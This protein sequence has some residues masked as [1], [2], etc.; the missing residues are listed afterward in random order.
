M[1]A[2]DWGGLYQ[3]SLEQTI[4]DHYVKR[5]R[6]WNELNSAIDSELHDS[7]RSY[8]QCSWYNHWSSVIIQD[9]FNDHPSVLPVIGLVKKVDFFIHDFPFDL[10]VTYFPDGYLQLL[11][12]REGLRPELAE[13]KTFCRSANIW[14]DN[15][16]PPSTLFMELIAKIA[17]HPSDN[18]RDFIT[19]FRATR[20]RLI[21]QTIQDPTDLKVW[22]YENQGVRRFDA[23][24][25][26][27]LI[28][29]D[30]KH[31][32]DS[33]KLKRNKVLLVEDINN[34]LNA[35][36]PDVM[37]SLKLSFKWRDE[38]FEAYSDI[39]FVLAD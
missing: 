39:L 31:V 3:N 37:E 10:K 21:Q 12:R 11:R 29:V 36:R 26:F 6:S 33:W 25:R 5:I 35:M 32:E 2:F 19:E 13:L 22:L 4:V 16:T 14:F 15:S 38:T 24:N 30:L 20:L 1:R 9:I 27:F 7:L 18:A 17:E 34:H 23:S 28:L 8:V